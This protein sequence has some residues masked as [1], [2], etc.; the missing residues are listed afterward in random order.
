MGVGT[1]STLENRACNVLDTEWMAEISSVNHLCES[2][3]QTKLDKSTE[4]VPRENESY[5]GKD[6]R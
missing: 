2:Q 1:Q 5:T 4:P 3:T 6:F